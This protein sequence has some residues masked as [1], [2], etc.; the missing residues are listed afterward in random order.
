MQLT[1]LMPPRLQTLSVCKRR[2][3]RPQVVGALALVFGLTFLSSFGHAASVTD[4]TYR[5]QGTRS[6]IARAVGTLHI[7][8]YNP[9]GPATDV[10]ATYSF[11]DN[12][13]F[14]P[15]G[16]MIGTGASNGQIL[17]ASLQAIGYVTMD[18]PPTP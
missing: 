11:H 5:N 13:L 18:D 12:H 14:D 1:V 9:S 7:Y 4:N 3:F 17:D 16:L 8:L 10:T 6:T 15:D 2:R